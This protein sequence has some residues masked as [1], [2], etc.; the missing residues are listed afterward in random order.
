MAFCDFIINMSFL[1]TNE[2]DFGG[3]FSEE[4]V[5]N[6]GNQPL[7]TPHVQRAMAS[8]TSVYAYA[9]SFIIIS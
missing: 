1:S 4:D 8:A 6:S 5:D 9:F 2:F 3:R 7:H